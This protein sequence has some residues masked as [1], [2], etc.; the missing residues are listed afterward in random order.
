MS[1]IL[2]WGFRATVKVHQADDESSLALKLKDD[3]NIKFS[4]FIK[5]DL[6]IL[7]PSKKLWLNPLLFNGTLQTLY[8]TSMDS[9]KKFLVYYGRELFT[10][11]DNG[12]CSLDWVIPKPKDVVSFKRLQKE[13]LPEGF[14]RLHPRCRYLTK[15][16]LTEL[17]N[18]DAHS[19]KPIVAIIHGL[20][21]G[22]HESLIRN[23]AEK[24]E[25]NTEGWGVVVINSRGCA[26]TK[27]TSGKL[28]TAGSTSDIRDVLLD[29][30]KR[31]PN[32]PIYL[33]GFSFGAALVSNFLAEEGD[34]ENPASLVKAACTICCPWDFVDGADHLKETYTGSYLLS[35]ALSKFLG[36]LITNNYK[37]LNKY[38]PDVINEKT[39]K[40]IET[41]NTL[42]DFDDKVTCKTTPYSSAFE[43]YK[44]LSPV[45]TLSHIKTPILA[46]NSTDDPAVGIKLPISQMKA[47]P[48]FCLV[49]T[50]LGGH[51][52][53][54]QKNGEFWC[55][56]LAEQFFQKFEEL[57]K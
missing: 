12:I 5:Q 26:R 2:G 19:T 4:Q 42:W 25:S 54:V 39:L 13:T 1:G 24:I 38:I 56:E 3:T 35:P 33:T 51:L 14:P 9:S 50:D 10:Y 8:Y 29:F 30:K 53:Y 34:T 36:K 49:E 21:G 17:H 31:W 6:P 15:E 55:V 16:E 27:I 52:G 22:S 45:N 18:D 37:E 48:Y 46:L 40:E 23:F 20:A 44:E 28:F 41:V 47:N 43:Y 11:E 32:R 7:D 57:I